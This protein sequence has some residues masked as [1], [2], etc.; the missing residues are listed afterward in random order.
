M[1]SNIITSLKKQEPTQLA[2][3]LH[4]ST[5]EQNFEGGMKGLVMLF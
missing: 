1:E 3:F 5:K 2:I 4:N